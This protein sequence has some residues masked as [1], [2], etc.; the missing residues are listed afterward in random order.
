MV[1]YNIECLIN[2][3][4]NIKNLQSKKIKAIEIP[5][6]Q[7]S[8]F[9]DAYA[10]GPEHIDIQA[11]TSAGEDKIYSKIFEY[12]IETI[13][14]QNTWQI[15]SEAYDF[16]DCIIRHTVWNKKSDREIYLNK[17]HQIHEY[18]HLQENDEYPSDR[19]FQVAFAGDVVRS[20][21]VQKLKELWFELNARIGEINTIEKQD[22]SEFVEKAIF[23]HNK[24]NCNFCFLWHYPLFIQSW[25]ECIDNIVYELSRLKKDDM[26]YDCN[27]CLRYSKNDFELLGLQNLM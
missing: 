3:N 22:E 20:N 15:Y 8:E 27:A 18:I 1:K 26:F 9:T 24:D 4:T 10:R 2:E 21:K 13:D 11:T 19:N 5:Y 17:T 23:V 12:Q 14:S 7:Y 25:E 16:F 6:L